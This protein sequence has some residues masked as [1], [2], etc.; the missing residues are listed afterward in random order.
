MNKQAPV[1]KRKLWLIPLLFVSVFGYFILK[2]PSIVEKQNKRDAR[3][4]KNFKNKF[5]EHFTGTIVSVNMPKNQPKSYKQTLIK[6]KLKNTT[7]YHYDTREQSLSY[8]FCV[9]DYP[10]AEVLITEQFNARVGEEFIYDGV[11]DVYHIGNNDI[12][13]EAD[14]DI[15][16]YNNR[17]MSQF[18]TIPKYNIGELEQRKKT[19]PKYKDVKGN[20]YYMLILKKSGNK[21]KI[22]R[23]RQKLSI[24]KNKLPFYLEKRKDIYYLFLTEKRFGHFSDAVK[25]WKELGYNESYIAK[26]DKHNN[27]INLMKKTKKL[28]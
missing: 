5:N 17:Y 2:S 23:Y 14:P 18:F 20:Y 22:D 4:I 1:N 7:I 27:F 24:N 26:F 13:Y 3:I 25:K 6:V 12:W 16:N 21:N 19:Y 11:D 10:F 15:I 28:E 9:I 8:I